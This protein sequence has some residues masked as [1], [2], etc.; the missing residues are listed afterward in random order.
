MLEHRETHLEA[1]VTLSSRLAA[2]SLALR[3]VG[4]PAGRRSDSGKTIVIRLDGQENKETYSE[5]EAEQ[6]WTGNEQCSHC[7]W[8][9]GFFC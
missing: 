1:H 3:L 7:L 8:R 2:C 4:M 9:A 6:K 5:G